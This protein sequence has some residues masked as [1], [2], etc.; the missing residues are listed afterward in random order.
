[1]PPYFLFALFPSPP[2][3]PASP[4]PCGPVALWQIYS[5]V[6]VLPTSTPG[7]KAVARHT[8]AKSKPLLPVKIPHTA[9]VPGHRPGCNRHQPEVPRAQPQRPQQRARAQAQPRIAH[10]LFRQVVQ[11]LRGHDV[12]IHH[13]GYDQ[14][15]RPQ[16]RQ[17]HR[18]DGAERQQLRKQ[19]AAPPIFHE[20][21]E[22]REYRRPD[23]HH[24]AEAGREQEHGQHRLR[25]R[26][27]RRHLILLHHVDQFAHAPVRQRPA[28]QPRH[29][30]GQQHQHRN[31]HHH[32]KRAHRGKRPDARFLRCGQRGE[33]ACYR[34]RAP[35]PYQQHQHRRPAKYPER[36]EPYQACR[37]EQPLQHPAPQQRQREV[38]PRSTPIYRC[39][40]YSFRAPRSVPEFHVPVAILPPPATL[41]R[42]GAAGSPAA[43]DHGCPAGPSRFSPH[44][45]QAPPADPEFSWW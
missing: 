38:N 6:P 34:R 31:R 8:A 21:E 3:P 9:H 45:R 30:E 12:E 28:H 18:G 14:Q 13:N 27:K 11:R 26:R 20:E 32:A 5:R 10:Q 39:H 15:K 16:C 33:L 2:S 23:Y 25:L 43:P 29:Q 22:Q 36:L 37:N 7:I 35:G 44:S 40:L 1:M 42:P 4:W 17:P 41:P 24:E 19:I